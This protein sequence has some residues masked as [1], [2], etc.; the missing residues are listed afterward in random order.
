METDNVGTGKARVYVMT[1]SFASLKIG[2]LIQTDE[3]I[4][5]VYMKKYNRAILLN[6][7]NQTKAI[8]K[9]DS[10]AVLDYKPVYEVEENLQKYAN[11]TANEYGI[12]VLHLNKDR[13][14]TSKI[15]QAGYPDCICFA[16]CG[17]SFFI[18]L[19]TKTKLSSEQELFRKWAIDMGFP[20]YV[21]TTPEEVDNIFKGYSNEEN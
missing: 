4:G 14:G 21:A 16:K 7:K 8:Q 13:T 6:E 11:D 10:Y 20:H 19:K 18:E 5:R 1:N 3:F 15:Q 12:R 17:R 2:W 9:D